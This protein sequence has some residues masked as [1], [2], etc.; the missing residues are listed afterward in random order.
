MS[1][2]CI[3]RSVS[4]S[5]VH[6]DPQA[7]NQPI[8]DGNAWSHG[9][10]VLPSISA[11]CAPPL[12]HIH[13][14]LPMLHC[15]RQVEQPTSDDQADQELQPTSLI[16][17]VL[18]HYSRKAA[19]GAVANRLASSLE[20]SRQWV[21]NLLRAGAELCDR[22]QKRTFN[23]L[24]HYVWTQKEAK[25]MHPLLV[26]VHVRYD[27][28]PQTL[29]VS[30][31]EGSAESELSKVYVARHS[32][33]L[34]VNVK[35]IANF[36]GADVEKPLLIRGCFS[37]AMRCSNT[38]AGESVAAVNRHMF[39]PEVPADLFDR[40]VRLIESDEAKANS[41]GERLLAAHKSG[42]ERSHIMCATHKIH[43]S[44]DKTMEV[45]APEA[46]C[47]RVS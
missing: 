44:A 14:C 23:K 3:L 13:A 45:A 17:K 9:A 4:F 6:S 16:A 21:W 31:G 33:S 27:E 42:W 10:H 24:L 39:D 2:C 47:P 37:T 5:Q 30:W 40:R 1:C 26:C 12:L 25:R 43:A 7:E 38:C 8:D 20:L 34:L 36:C 18:V 22:S 29:R 41:R 46:V 28:T 11:S 19:S 15:H 32:W 35:Q